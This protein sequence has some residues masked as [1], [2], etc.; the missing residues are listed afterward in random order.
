MSTRIKTKI[1]LYNRFGFFL[2]FSPFLCL[3]RRVFIKKF[4]KVS[5][6]VISVTEKCN[7]NCTYCNYKNQKGKSIGL[8]K[9]K[10]IVNEANE[11]GI[12]EIVLIGGEPFTHEN[13]F[14]MLYYCQRKKLKPSV[15]TNGTLINPFN[16]HKLKKIR[17]LSLVFKFDS[18]FSYKKHVGSNLYSQVAKTMQ[19]CKQGGIHVIAN[20]T[21]TNNNVHI[22]KETLDKAFELGAEP[23]IERHIPLKDNS[24]NNKLEL[25]ATNWQNSLK[26]FCSCYAEHLGVNPKRFLT[27]VIWKAKLYGYNQYMC[28]GFYTSITIR[29]NGRAVPCGLAP[30]ELSVGNINKEPLSAILEKYYQ[31]RKIWRTIPLECEACEEAEICRGG[32]KAYT[33][34]KLKR[35]DKKDPLCKGI[36]D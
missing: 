35:F 11:N 21:V 10:K 12:K 28:K 4:N 31:Q 18:P 14:E 25:S 30:D 32:C 34:L 22:L 29:T 6:L 1:F 7:L 36:C 2:S 15:Y 3:L 23:R 13:I 26:T 5:T 9:F 16:V 33:Y 8:K 17:M 27:Y 24:T 20:I 19:L